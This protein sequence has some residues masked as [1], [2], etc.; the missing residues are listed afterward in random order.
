MKVINLNSKFELTQA[1]ISFAESVIICGED[2]P[3]RG[4]SISILMNEIPVLLVDSETQKEYGNGDILGFYQ[5]SGRILGIEIPVIGLCLEKIINEVKTDEELIILIAKVL[6]HEFAHAKMALHPNA[7][8][9]PKDEFYEW[10]EEPMANL[11]TL[12]YFENYD[13]GYKHRRTKLAYATTLISPFDYVKDFISKQPANYR[14]GLDL[15]EHRV[16]QW[17]IWRNEKDN[18]QKKT[19]EKQAWLNYVKANVGKTDKV[20]LDKLF[21]QLYK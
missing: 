2:E 10:M 3:I 14:L 16:C 11:I 19:N 20:M 5:H 12:E 6:I 1:Q 18:I 4:D 15:F 21:K 17:W 7:N 13:R 8:Y 9:Y